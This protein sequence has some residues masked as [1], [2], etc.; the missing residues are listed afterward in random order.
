[1]DDEIINAVW[2]KAKTAEGYNPDLVRLDSCGAL[3][4]KSEYCNRESQ[5]GWEI[6]H[7]FSKYRGGGDDLVNLRPMQWENNDSKSDDFPVYWSAVTAGDNENV[8]LRQRMHVNYKLAD[9]LR[10]LYQ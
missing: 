10:N 6:D 3:I 8:R 4:L 5:F 2:K 7:V 1:M 9:E